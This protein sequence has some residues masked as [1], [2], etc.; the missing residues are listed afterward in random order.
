MY[1]LSSLARRQAFLGVVTGNASWCET[2]SGVVDA[3]L[4]NATTPWAN[5]SVK[6]LTSYMMSAGV[7]MAHDWCAPA[8][9]ATF[10]S[11]VSAA[12]AA[13][14]DMISTNGGTQQNT[15]PASNWQFSR[16]AS[17]LLAYL[18]TDEPVSPANFNASLARMEAYYL[19]SVG[20]ANGTNSSGWA[21]ESLGYTLYP[22]GNFGAVGPA[23][24]RSPA[25][26]DARR[27]CAGARHM[28]QTEYTAVVAIWNQS[29]LAHAD[30]SDDNPGWLQEGSAGLAYWWV[31][32]ALA[33]G[34]RW[35][36]DRTSG[37]LSSV[38]TEPS[39]DNATAGT[40][41]S[42]LY[43][44]LDVPPVDPSTLPAWGD[45]FYDTLGNG[46]FVWRR[47]YDVVRSDV[48]W[49]VY[50]KLRGQQ[51]HCAPDGG[52]I[53]LIGLGNPWI[54]GGGRYTNSDNG[55]PAYWRSQVR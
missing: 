28:I 54:V 4:T 46:H 9:N 24:L 48:S 14:G 13:M 36:A 53:R 32:A 33:P 35:M 10:A 8:W 42:V 2:V 16:G 22:Q 39:F 26:V 20:A 3:M 51:G 23:L 41:W 50:A 29:T 55:V 31:D 30:W 27:W 37:L 1:D 34:L 11:R 52:G 17:S 15:D 12:L 7:A 21:I 49:E 6:G 40:V 25:G 43:T 45:T 44:P 18:A 47:G 5:G 38:G 19:A